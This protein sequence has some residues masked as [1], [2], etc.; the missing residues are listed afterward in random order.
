MWRKTNET[1]APG[2][3]GN[4]SSAAPA[5]TPLKPQVNSAH[6]RRHRRLH[7]SSATTAQRSGTD[8]AVGGAASR[9]CCRRA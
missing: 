8:L 4:D 5:A 7:H 6:N 2:Q 1:K 9:A 3:V